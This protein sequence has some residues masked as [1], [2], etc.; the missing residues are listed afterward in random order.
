MLTVKGL[1][2]SERNAGEQDKYISVLTAEC[3]TIDISV[4]GANKIT[5]KNHAATQLF[6]YSSLCLNMRKDRYYLNSSEL[7]HDFY[8]LRLDIKKLAL[9]CYI[10]EAAKYS[11]MA[12]NRQHENNVMRLVLNCLHMLDK[13]KRSCEFIKSVFELRFL[14]EIGMMPQLIGCR[15][16]Y[17]YDAEEMFFLIDKAYVLCADDF[18]AKELEESY[19]NVKI[20][21]QQLSALQFICLA[22][23]DRLFN[24]RLSEASQIKINEITEKYLLVHLSRSFKSLEYYHTVS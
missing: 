7:I 22:D 5:G 12:S 9:A 1:V 4:K 17:V 19:Y 8:N 21:P 23:F 20:T 3:G 18:Y 11:V 13:D 6:A 2:V 15:V 14:S 16:C 10:G 24:F